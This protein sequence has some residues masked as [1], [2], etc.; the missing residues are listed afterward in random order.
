MAGGKI[1]Y[2]RLLS[3]HELAGASGPGPPL[4]PAETASG[5][6]RARSSTE[7]RGCPRHPQTQPPAHLSRPRPRPPAPTAVLLGLPQPYPGH[8][9]PF[10]V[11]RASFSPV[12]GAQ[13]QLSPHRRCHLPPTAKPASAMS[14]R[15]HQFKKR[16]AALTAPSIGCRPHRPSV[17]H[18]LI[19]HL[20]EMSRPLPRPFWPA[21]RLLPS[22]TG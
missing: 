11:P 21:L 7:Q 13:G 14:G 22:L 8:T 6:K 10:P 20:S 15:H 17:S 18:Y 2:R 4:C 3:P 5:L 19:R 12:P 9:R 1:R 16:A